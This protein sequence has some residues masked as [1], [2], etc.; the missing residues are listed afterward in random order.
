MVALL[1]AGLPVIF[2][3]SACICL[4]SQ[5]LL[6]ARCDQSWNLADL[7][8]RGYIYMCILLN[9]LGPGPLV[10]GASVEVAMANL[11]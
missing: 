7:D 3:D 2:E 9:M 8:G 5:Q 4:T 11:T 1:A 6:P 10:L